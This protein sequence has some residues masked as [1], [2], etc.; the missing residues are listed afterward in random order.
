MNSSPSVKPCYRG[1]Q[2]QRKDQTHTLTLSHSKVQY[3][4][5]TAK[6]EAGE[7]SVDCCADHRRRG[8]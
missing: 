6:G 5:G 4:T 2:N 1:L 3:K 8:R 7:V